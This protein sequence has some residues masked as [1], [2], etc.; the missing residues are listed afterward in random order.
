M[1]RNDGNRNENISKM[2]YL[3]YSLFMKQIYIMLPIDSEFSLLYFLYFM[4]F[5]YITYQITRSKRA[6]KIRLSLIIIVSVLLNM[7]FFLNPK[8]FEGGGSLVVLFYSG[9]I[10]F[11]NNN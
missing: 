6:N 1:E 10:F 4:I 9:I 11:R 7:I 2:I 3:L 5:S 8:N